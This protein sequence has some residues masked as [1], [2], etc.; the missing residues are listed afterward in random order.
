MTQKHDM[1]R[2]LIDKTILITGAAGGIGR[3]TALCCASAGASLMLSDVNA[4]GCGETAERATELG[5]TVHTAACDVSQAASVEKLVADTV[6]RFGRIDGAFNNA[7]VEGDTANTVRWTEEAFDR[8]I[9]INL[10]GVWLCM[11]YQIPAMLASGG[12]SIVNTAS[13]AGLVGS[14]GLS[15]Y[16]ASK[17]GVVG[18]SKVAAVE[19]SRKG[20]RV[21]AVCPGMIDTPM[22]DRL[23]SFVKVPKETTLLQQPIGRFGEPEEI[24][25]AVAWL[26]SDAASLVTGVAM[27]VD[28]G[29]TAQ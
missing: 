14:R 20:V 29:M 25:E 15:G 12:G 19:F 26:L 6:A 13:A 10:K 22:L 24:G 28:G 18:L 27:P 23:L 8:T 1:V 11:K 9:A 5:A 3:A 16:A 4:D 2:G 7:G 21:N 17:H